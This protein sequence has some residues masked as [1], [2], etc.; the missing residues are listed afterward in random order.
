M[1]AKLNTF[2]RNDII[3][4]SLD[5]NFN[6]IIF[7]MLT[8]KKTFTLCFIKN[9]SLFKNM[10]LQQKKTNINFLKNDDD[11]EGDNITDEGII[12]YGNDFINC[13]TIHFKQ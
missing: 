5:L 1:G 4:M 7:H 10:K 8:V 12:E 6:D 11:L 13:K 3:V 9:M 2:E